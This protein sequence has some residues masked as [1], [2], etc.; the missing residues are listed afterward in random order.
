MPDLEDLLRR[1]ADSGRSGALPAP[2]STIRGIG[3]RMRR[4][5]V[6]LTATCSS[7]VV[8]GLVSWVT[9]ATSPGA[10]TPDFAT[11]TNGG[12]HNSTLPSTAAQNALLTDADLE[13]LYSPG[14]PLPYVDPQPSDS[15]CAEADMSAQDAMAE[16]VWTSSGTGDRVAVRQGIEEASSE[17][18]ANQRLGAF[19]TYVQSCGAAADGTPNDALS[20]SWKVI[21]VG[22]EAA[23]DV[24]LLPETAQDR[25]RLVIAYLARNGTAVTWITLTAYGQDFDGEPDIAVLERAVERLCADYGGACVGDKPTVTRQFPP[26]EPGP[27]LSSTP[28][29]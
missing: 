28:S 4:T 20:S 25:G 17:Q 23:V 29:S 8:V 3:T 1:A 7:L 14:G 5:R 9:T 6:T 22:D 15:V 13:H 21:G 18:V 16:H 10:T 2:A 11:S 12:Q 19:E 24:F 27:G 26:T